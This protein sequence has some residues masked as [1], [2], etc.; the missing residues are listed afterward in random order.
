MIGEEKLMRN[1]MTEIHDDDI[2][3]SIEALL[4]FRP[5]HLHEMERKI[6]HSIRILCRISEVRGLPSDTAAFVKQTTDAMREIRMLASLAHS[7]LF[8]QEDQKEADEETEREA[9]PIEI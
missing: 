1:M 9:E 7:F 2:D 5:D 4:G 3:A 8:A 6:A